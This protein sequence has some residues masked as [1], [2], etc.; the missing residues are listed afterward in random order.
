[1]ADWPGPCRPP[2]AIRSPG[3]QPFP[4]NRPAF[5]DSELNEEGSVCVGT[6]N[7]QGE[8]SEM[9]SCPASSLEPT[10]LFTTFDEDWGE[11]KTFFL[12][13]LFLT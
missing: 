10:F 12:P 3:T 8:E 4:Y 2:T 6:L 7:G 11:S 5:P 13:L 1:M 9:G